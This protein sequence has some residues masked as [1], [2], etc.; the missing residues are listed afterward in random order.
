MSDTTNV[1]K[2]K[3]IFAKSDE[4]LAG[5]WS[6]L[7]SL[8]KN[9]EKMEWRNSQQLASQLMQDGKASAYVEN[10]RA[11]FNSTKSKQ[12]STSKKKQKIVKSKPTKVVPINTRRD[13]FSMNFKRLLQIAP[14][15]IERLERGEEVY[16]KSIKTGYDDFSIELI[17]TDKTG[18]YLALAHYYKQ[19]GDL[20]PDP[21]M[22]IL[23]DPE[24]EV[25]QA[26]AFQNARYYREVYNDIYDRKLVNPKEKKAQNAFLEDWLKN[27]IAQDQIV[28]WQHDEEDV[29]Q[30]ETNAVKE[31][32]ADISY[33]DE[34]LISPMKELAEKS[35]LDD[36]I[37]K[38]TEHKDNKL[39]L[40]PIALY[41]I[42]D[43]INNSPI[44]ANLPYPSGKDLKADY[45]KIRDFDSKVEEVNQLLS[46]P[47]PDIS[48]IPKELSKEMKLAIDES[49]L[50]EVEATYVGY[51][52]GK[53]KVNPISLYF[54]AGR[55]N[56]R[57][58]N[59]PTPY[60]TE[61][62]IKEFY[63]T[64]KPE[65]YDQAFSELGKEVEKMEKFL[66][67]P[68]I[69]KSNYKKLLQITPDLEEQLT[70]HGLQLQG[71]SERDD[72][73]YDFI[74]KVEEKS[75][76][77]D[78]YELLIVES[79]YVNKKLEEYTAM[80]V[81]FD[82]ISKELKASSTFLPDGEV[83]KV[84]DLKLNVGITY[85]SEEEDQNEY[86]TKWLDE[87]IEKGHKIETWVPIFEPKEIGKA[88]KGE[89]DEP[90]TNLTPS[91]P[92]VN[93]HEKV[94]QNQLLKTNFQK[95][96]RLV[97]NLLSILHGQTVHLA[98]KK[99]DISLDISFVNKKGEFALEFEITEFASQNKYWTVMIQGTTEKVLVKSYETDTKGIIDISSEKKN[100]DFG[101][102][103][104]KKVKLAY[105]PFD[106]IKDTLLKNQP[107]IMEWTEGEHKKGLRFNHIED[108]EAKFKS[109][110]FTNKPTE[111]YIKNKVWFKDYSTEIRI[112]LSDAQADY[113]PK[114]QKLLDWLKSY[115]SKFDWEQFSKKPKK[116]SRKELQKEANKI[117]DFEVGKVKL[118]EAHVKAGLTQ[119]DIDFINKHKQGLTITPL[120]RMTNKT[121]DFGADLGKKAK[122]PGFRISQTGKL[123]Y[124]TRSNRSDMTDAGL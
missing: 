92:S 76:T 112:D 22:Q 38:Y 71:R 115:D 39:S 82:S 33:M 84:Y 70:K 65:G 21:D 77:N 1:Y 55:L 61:N 56:E 41:F 69:F 73:L 15:L 72:L 12:K 32:K 40:R 95:L 87:L 60:P 29:S 119:K 6:R 101:K 59:P 107:I 23:V 85:E 100:S 96:L 106:Q 62:E 113:N 7:A 118:V 98:S 35:I 124:E 58:S 104:T 123:Y 102:W 66:F 49:S 57:K 42:V 67:D 89:S 25:I 90:K 91:K 103:L 75:I 34:S 37:K 114:K 17:F 19:N 86:L 18:Y 122:R 44:G 11:S 93:R 45:E 46:N 2:L 52:D 4:E 120:N 74:L 10:A 14:D 36:V 88:D 54:I 105:K 121:K 109:Y 117:P 43:R 110:G 20:V 28:E 5:N 9:F 31:V 79:G 78:L 64:L 26:L 111:T 27:L 80:T 53:T 116:K 97:P 68:S 8:I 30:T 94:K 3:E 99:S 83:K 51:T 13:R 63:E 81:L 50:E 47:K 16:G 48:F 24:M 108:L